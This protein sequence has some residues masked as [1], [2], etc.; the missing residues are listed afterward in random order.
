[1]ENP[2]AVDAGAPVAP[3]VTDE[4]VRDAG[5]VHRK[6]TRI[7]VWLGN[8]WSRALTVIDVGVDGCVI[9]DDSSGERFVAWCLIQ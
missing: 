5:R 8:R 7:K 9:D 3:P 1:M 4:M 2:K 6:G